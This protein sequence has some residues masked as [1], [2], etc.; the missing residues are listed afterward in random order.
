MVNSVDNLDFGPPDQK[1]FRSGI[2]FLV[3]GVVLVLW[4]WGSWIY[5]SSGT[6][7]IQSSINR[8]Q[9]Y[10]PDLNAGADYPD[11]HEVAKTLPTFIMFGFIL[12]VVF[13][14]AIF[15]L[16]RTTRRYLAASARKRAPPTNT[17]DI[18]STHKLPDD[19]FGN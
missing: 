5:R 3:M 8:S 1:R 18:W 12:F 14:V 13:L 17:Q 2:V 6:S 9:N 11:Q 7:T 16:V 19:D 15:I 10:D 4:A